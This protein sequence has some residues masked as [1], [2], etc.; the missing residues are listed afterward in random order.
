MQAFRYCTCGGQS[1]VS[2]YGTCQP[3]NGFLFP[4]LHPWSVP[5]CCGCH[6]EG[7]CST[8][9]LCALVYK[10]CPL[11]DASPLLL[12]LSL[13]SFQAFISKSYDATTH[14]ETTCDDVLDMYE[15]V[16]GAPFDFSQVKSLV[17]VEAAE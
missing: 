6:S 13:S 14:F 5:Q 12:S 9:G 3:Q 8:G 15:R 1:D 7:Q 16:T 10:A 2:W 4:Y 11:M 17:Q